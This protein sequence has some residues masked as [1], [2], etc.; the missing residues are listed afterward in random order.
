MKLSQARVDVDMSSLLAWM[1]PSAGLCRLYTV[2]LRD[3][4]T[5]EAPWV[6]PRSTQKPRAEHGDGTFLRR[7]S[8]HG[9]G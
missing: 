7:N 4:D 9:L 6:L 3:V 2:V 1:I 5:A 8:C